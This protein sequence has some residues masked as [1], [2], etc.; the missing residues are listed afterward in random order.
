MNYKGV[1][2]NL[3]YLTI[4]Q[5]VN[6]V[7]PLITYPFLIKTIGSNNFGKVVF[8]Q[9]LFGYL[10]IIISF[11]FNITGAREIGRCNNILDRNKVASS[12]IFSKFILLL[13]ISLPSF[14]ILKFNLFSLE[15]E[16][17]EI[18]IYSMWNLLFEFFLPI[19]FFQ[20]INKLKYI[21]I[22]NVL[23][24]LILTV[25]IF[26]L[27]KGKNDNLLFVKLNLYTT[28]VYGIGCFYF[29]KLE[30]F[31]FVK[32]GLNDLKERF[33][34]SYVMAFA[35]ISNA[36]KSNFSIVLIKPLIGYQNIAYFDMAQKVVNIFTN[37]LDLISQAIFPIILKTENIDFLKKIIKISVI[38]SLF[39]STINFLLAE[40][41]VR[42]LGGVEMSKS[43]IYLQLL[44]LNY[45]PYIFAALI[46]RNCLIVFNR[47]FEVL[48][49][50]FFSGL[51]FIFFI[52]FIYVIKP[53]DPIFYVI[54]AILTSN[55]F[56]AY[57][58]FLKAKTFLKW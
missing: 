38:L 19:W 20:G 48:K 37:F 32:I 40:Y 11:G 5:I 16:L 6:M 55:I 4:L 24:K 29:Y 31:F 57:Y 30:S 2:K 9:N 28:I 21:T 25:L 58:R 7:L 17:I 14:L 15:K 26:T 50:M 54:I 36:I 13:T 8:F 42:I 53:D 46:G 45:T 1:L 43:I 47:D 3:S 35:Y 56:E 18:A 41:I 33:R 23:L 34:A 27:I 10:A 52:F 12:I 44:G 39:I 49:S 22:L 51:F